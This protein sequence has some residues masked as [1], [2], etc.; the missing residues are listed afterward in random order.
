MRVFLVEL[1]RALGF[2]EKPGSL[3]R[4]GIG[5]AIVLLLATVALLLYQR[6][7][8]E[9]AIK[10]LMAEAHYLEASQMAAR[11]LRQQPEET[12]IR[13]LAT[14]ALLQGTLPGWQQQLDAQA[15]ENARQR[16]AALPLNDLHPQGRQLLA[17]LGWVTDLEQWFAER[18]PDNHL[19]LY[20]DEQ[21]IRA[22]LERWEDQGDDA[23]RLLDLIRDQEPAFEA[24]HSRIFSRLRQLENER[25]VYLT[26]IDTL[27]RRLENLLANNRSDELTA[28]L[29]DFVRQYPTIRGTDRL[30][31][32]I[33]DYRT[34]HQAIGNRDLE[35]L[36]RLTLGL[37]FRTPPFQQA[38]QELLPQQLPPPE[39]V[40]R[41][42][43]ARRAWLAG[44]AQQAIALLEPATVQPWGAAL[45]PALQHYRQV[46]SSYRQLQI[47]QNAADYGPALIA[48][49]GSL[50]PV[51]DRHYLDALQAAFRQYTDEARRNADAAMAAAA[52]YWQQ[53][54]QQGA[55]AAPCAWK[56]ISPS[57]FASRHC[58]STSPRMKRARG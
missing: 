54:Q 26:G 15:Y 11:I 58:C 2:G 46:E 16:L 48:F 37:G 31:Q 23:R 41:H 24:R 13:T 35:A 40:E 47:R 36:E 45:E 57:V 17:L 32:D 53:Y 29:D 6:G 52:D 44:D 42:R 10:A 7:A 21:P 18:P 19:E 22:L 43:Q 38:S 5:A 8:E 51:L 12:E 56:T 33:G 49:Y 27:N 50:D 39:I 3:K 14:S 28:L 1:R 34:L 9:R 55:S 25:S 4:R 20:R 30:R